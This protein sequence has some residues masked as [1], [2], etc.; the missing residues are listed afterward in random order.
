MQSKNSELKSELT[1]V[2]AHVELYQLQVKE[3]SDELDREKAMNSIKETLEQESGRIIDELKAQITTSSKIYEEQ[4]Q[5]LK[6]ANDED[7]KKL[8]EGHTAMLEDV[9]QSYAA[10]LARSKSHLDES[11]KAAKAQELNELSRGL[12]EHKQVNALI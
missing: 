7:V 12:E 3:L 4:I 8:R 10:E 2:K 11:L 1:Q 6:Q 5:A 9:R